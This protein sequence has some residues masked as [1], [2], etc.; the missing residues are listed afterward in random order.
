MFNS[1]VKLP[2]GSF[3]KKQQLPKVDEMRHEEKQGLLHQVLDCAALS[4][5]LGYET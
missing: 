5:H 3:P 2:E 1:Y 4:E